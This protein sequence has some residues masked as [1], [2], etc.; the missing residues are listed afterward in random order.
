LHLLVHNS[1]G[2]RISWIRLNWNFTKQTIPYWIIVQKNSECRK[3]WN[4]VFLYCTWHKFIL[5]IQIVLNLQ[6][7]HTNMTMLWYTNG[8]TKLWFWTDS[9]PFHGI[10]KIPNWTNLKLRKL[11]KKLTFRSE[12]C[13]TLKINCR[14]LLNRLTVCYVLIRVDDIGYDFQV[15][16]TTFTL[17]LN[18]VMPSCKCFSMYVTKWVVHT[19]I[20]Q[21]FVT[22]PYLSLLVMRLWGISVNIFFRKIETLNKYYS[23][24]CYKVCVTSKYYSSVYH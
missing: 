15:F 14:S 13:W 17:L 4:S 21:L 22:P 24:G 3:S 5:Q 7:Q 18:T 8:A 19:S 6:S 11:K 2:L 12:S 9:E 20:I 16:C 10:C 1:K 23:T